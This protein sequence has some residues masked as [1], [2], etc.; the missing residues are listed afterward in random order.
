M[1]TVWSPQQERVFQWAQDEQGSAI[2]EA[3]AGAGK[4]TTLVELVTRL[5]GYV[6]FMAFNKAIAT[7]IQG[8]LDARNVDGT[9]VNAGTFH[10]FGFQAWRKLAPKVKVEGRKLMI[11]ADEMQMP[12]HMQEFA[13][14]GVG[15]ARQW[16][17]GIFCAFDDAAQ[18]RMLV[19]R[20]ELD[21][22]LVEN[23]ERVDA[24]ELDE[25]VA[26]ATEWAVRLLKESVKASMDMI[27]FDD[28]LY[29]PLLRD[30]KFFQR[31]WVLVDEAQDTNPVR[32]ALAKKMLRVGGRLVAVGD[33]CQAIYGFSGADSESL[34][35]IA[36][37]F[38]AVRLPLTVTYRCPKSIVNHARQWVSHIEAHAS[39]PEGI[40]RTV[41][42]AEFEKYTAEQ[43]RKD[44][45]VLCRNTKPLVELAFQFIR[46]GIGCHVEGRDI[47][48]G[49]IALTKKYKV[50][51]VNALRG[52]LQQYM[53][54]EVQK[55]LAK[56]QETKAAQV[57][58]KVTTLFV[59]MDQ[60]N[61]SDPV[62]AIVTKINS[63][64]GDT[65]EGKPAKS[66]TLSTIHKAKGR[67]WHRVYW[68]GRNK[69]Q[70]SKFAR[71]DWQVEQEN[72]LMY[73][74]ATRAKEELIEVIVPTSNGR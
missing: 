30:V 63:I 53:E 19:D 2:V 9:K 21:D 35:Q 20:F 49:L 46:R 10:S 27:D 67:E 43:L 51:T 41:E 61:G 47:G 39:A 45:V 55:A 60:L 22:S 12:R 18:W 38:N 37:Q 69:F 56:G 32:L 14:K 6:A 26:E 52:R 1:E 33:P 48:A 3:V 59:I 17:I 16:G 15:L 23:G 71:Q 57:E 66:L 42:A 64:F 72:N 28:M 7:E 54:R 65:E 34:N 11:L 44:D 24:V 74:A 36:K 8:K 31:D 29:M 4:T 50:K 58:D 70:P 25:R 40:V 5:N 73:V 62:D 68:Y 13:R